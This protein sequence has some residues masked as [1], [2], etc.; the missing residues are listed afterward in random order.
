MLIASSHLILRKGRGL[1]EQ[2]DW[3]NLAYATKE[4]SVFSLEDGVVFCLRL[5]RS[6]QNLKKKH[7]HMNCS[8][9]PHAFRKHTP[10]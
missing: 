3:R 1:S 4:K 8:Q 9:H 5:M 7:A 2:N 6:K 10:L